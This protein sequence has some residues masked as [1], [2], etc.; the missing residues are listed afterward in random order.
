MAHELG[1]LLLGT[2]SHAVDGLMRAH[3]DWDNLQAAERNELLFLHPEATEMTKR[4]RNAEAPQVC[5]TDP[6]QQAAVE[7]PH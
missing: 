7:S 5:V 4:L 2:N 6:Q 3:W 1:H